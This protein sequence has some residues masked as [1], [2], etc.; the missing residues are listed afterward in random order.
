MVD[1]I[2]RLDISGGTEGIADEDSFDVEVE[3]EG[4]ASIKVFQF[5]YKY[6]LVL[7][8][9]IPS[10]RSHFNFTQPWGDRLDRT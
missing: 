2:D 1:E 5:W 10:R 7:Y 9:I 8:G 3:D 4:L 6:K